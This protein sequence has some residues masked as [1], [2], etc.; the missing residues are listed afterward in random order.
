[1]NAGAE[2]NSFD[3]FNNTVLHQA[4][5]SGINFYYYYFNKKDMQI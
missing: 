1:M 2:L 4:A 3:I 5:M